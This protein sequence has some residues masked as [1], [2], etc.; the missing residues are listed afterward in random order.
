MANQDSRGNNNTKYWREK[1][2]Q[3]DQIRNKGKPLYFALPPYKFGE[4]KHA[5]KPGK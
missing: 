5:S 2:M 1:K 3:Y 4:V